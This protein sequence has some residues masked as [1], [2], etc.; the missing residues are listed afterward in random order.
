MRTCDIHTLYQTFDA[1]YYS[2]R[3]SGRQRGGGGVSQGQ[4]EKLFSSSLWLCLSFITPFPR[5]KQSGW[6]WKGS[7]VPPVSGLMCWRGSERVMFT[8][9]CS[10]NAIV[11]KFHLISATLFT[12]LT[13][14]PVWEAAGA[15]WNLSHT[16]TLT[17]IGVW[18]CYKVACDTKC[19]V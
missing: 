12:E 10:L 16:H 14:E 4:G 18:V 15:S 13:Q 11:A 19:L 1:F 7:I 2:V 17:W 3:A 8:Q 9:L 6:G 5:G